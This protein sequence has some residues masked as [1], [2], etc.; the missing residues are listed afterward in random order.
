MP[1]D[2]LAITVGVGSSLFDRRFGLASQQPIHLVPMRSFPN[3]NLD[4]A[5]LGGDL[6]LQICA[7]SGDTALH[8]L[9]DIAKHTRGGMQIRW[10]LD[11]SVAPPRPVGVPRNHLGFKVASRIRTSAIPGS[12]TGCFGSR[13]GSASRAGRS[14]AP[15]T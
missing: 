9:R 8:A 4:P 6:L 14:A 1:T 2:G 13:A 15:T 7:G 12:P 10:R 3:D 11:G 5:L